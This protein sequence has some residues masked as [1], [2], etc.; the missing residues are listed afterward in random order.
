MSVGVEVAERRAGDQSPGRSE[1][2][3]Q[4]LSEPELET[5]RAPLLVVRD[6]SI[7][8]GGIVALDRVSF[9]IARGEVLGLIGPN[10]AGKTTLFNCVTRLYTP[11][12]GQILFDGEDLLSKPAHKIAPLGITRSFQNLALFRRLSVLDNIRIG[13]H[14]RTNGNFISDAMRL[15][16]GRRRESE[17]DEQ[18]WRLIRELDLAAVAH[19]LVTDLST[20]TQKRVE[21][22]RALAA[23]PKLLLLDEP[24]AGLNHNE[25]EELGRLIRQV[26]DQHH[27]TVLLVEHHMN[28][29]M[30]IS[31]R[32][33]A[34]D[35]GRKIAD[36]T[37]EQVREH[38]EVIRA[39]LGKAAE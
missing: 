34:L 30:S 6:V 38:P 39:Y 20:G 17:S 23:Q 16:A 8:F 32:V 28:L 35:F 25:V 5:R 10:G 9:E 1:L 14:A 33:V 2:R 18:V 11:D 31:D 37:P 21:M 15:P 24:A 27:V 22:A 29:V 19:R 7:R 36:G 12:S 13:T 4:T 3:P 26:R